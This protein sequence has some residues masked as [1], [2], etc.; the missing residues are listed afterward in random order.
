MAYLK[1]LLINERLFHNASHIKWQYTL[2]LAGMVLFVLFYL[3]AAGRYPGGSWANPAQVGFSWRHNYLCDLLDDRAVNGALNAGR[4]WARASLAV[5]CAGILIL[6]YHLP[7]LTDGP[8]WNRRLIRFSGIIALGTT[9]FLNAGTHDITVRIAGFF[10]TIAMTS[11]IYGLWKGMRRSISIFGAVCLGIL[12]LNYVIYETGSLLPALP[13]IQ[14]VTFSCFLIW[15][16]WMD[17]TLIRI[18]ASNNT[19]RNLTSG[20]SY[21]N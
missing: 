15:L 12:L 16:G 18:S 17:T 6:W 7:G 13:L 11:L 4:Y 5:L 20:D 1:E 21:K 19:A 8:P 2:P 3:L 9:V 14:K 10:G